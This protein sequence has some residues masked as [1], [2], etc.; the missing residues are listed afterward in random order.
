MEIPK[1]TIALVNDDSLIGYWNNDEIVIGGN[2]I[3]FPNE[4]IINVFTSPLLIVSYQ[5]MNSGKIN[6]VHYRIIKSDGAVIN[7]WSRE[8][9]ADRG[10]PFTFIDREKNIF[11]LTPET[12]SYQCYSPSGRIIGN[13]QLF[14]END[15]N[16]EKSLLISQNIQGDIVLAGMATPT[17]T[18]SNNVFL[19]MLNDDLSPGHNI[20]VDLTIPYL[21][22]IST[23]GN[24]AVFG[25]RSIAGGY[26]QEPLLYLLTQEGQPLTAPLGFPTVPKALKW[27]DN[28]LVMLSDDKLTFINPGQTPEITSVDLPTKVLPIDWIIT[29]KNIII[30]AGRNIQYEPEGFTYQQLKLVT[31]HFASN[32]FDSQTI[33]RARHR[34]TILIPG[35]SPDRFFL[36]FD[37]RILE[38]RTE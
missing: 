29:D 37:S 26:E 9:S 23:T 10:I 28:Q 16:H 38:Y 19:F 15:W 13:Y 12:Q 33:S 34:K 4:K 18:G 5:T 27:F 1:Q 25:T 3:Q 2:T 35:K 30:I 24:I 7:Q 22:D 36:Q 6:I 31:Y 20:A 32:T 17:L 21:L 14:D 11:L 8:L